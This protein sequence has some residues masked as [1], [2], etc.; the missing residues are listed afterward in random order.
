[1]GRMS[2]IDP[3]YL[4]HLVCPLD[5]SSLRHAG[6]ELIS[7]NGRRYP[8]VEGLPVM[9][10]AEKQQTIALAHASI[11][12]AQDKSKPVDRQDAKLYLESLGVSEDEKLELVKLS[13][14]KAISLDPVVMVLLG[15][16]CGIAYKPLIANRSLKEYPIPPI[17]LSP[18]EPGATLLDV[19]C[20]WGRWSV[21]AAR[22]G[23]STVGMDPSLGAIMAARRVAKKLCLDIKYVVADARFMPFGNEQF[24]YIYSYSVLQ[25][26]SRSDARSAISE[27]GRVLTSGGVAKIQMPNKWGVRS[28]QHQAMRMFCEPKDFEVRYWTISELIHTFSELIG[29]TRISAD[30]YFGLGWQWHDLRYLAPRHKPIVIASETLKRLSNLAPPLRMIADSLFC[31]SIKV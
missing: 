27:M 14:D 19:G 5:R 11:E 25:H 6:D 12:R 8:I 3:W 7:A 16:T 28:L 9:L 22:K 2:S 29:N 13:Q 21:A 18:S 31:T 30:C 23:F 17:N 4:D 20:S 24:R 15:A 10:L 26:F 1:M